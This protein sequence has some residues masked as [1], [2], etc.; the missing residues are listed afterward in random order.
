MLVSRSPILLLRDQRVRSTAHPL[1][2]LLRLNSLP[3]RPNGMDIGEGLETKQ[4]RVTRSTTLSN[5]RDRTLTPVD[6]A[7][8]CALSSGCVGLDRYLI[9]RECTNKGLLEIFKSKSVKGSLTIL[10]L[11]PRLALFSR[12]KRNRSVFGVIGS[13]IR[14]LCFRRVSHVP[15]ILDRGD[16]Q[17]LSIESGLGD[18]QKRRKSLLH[19]TL[20]TRLVSV[21]YFV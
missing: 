2:L 19:R 20:G 13:R 18:E 12:S 11:S 3:F 9:D 15:R 4:D 14:I 16:P 1:L 5:S 10:P 21:L 7:Q 8:G 17:R 6:F